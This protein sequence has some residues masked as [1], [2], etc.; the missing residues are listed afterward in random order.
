VGKERQR[1]VARLQDGEV[2]QE[3]CAQAPHELEEAVGGEVVLVKPAL[4]LA[5][6][7]R[8]RLKAQ[9]LFLDPRP[10]LL[11]QRVRRLVGR[12]REKVVPRGRREAGHDAHKLPRQVREVSLAKHA[13]VLAAGLQDLRKQSAIYLSVLRAY[14]SRQVRFLSRD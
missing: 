6:A 5:A 7:A 14:P 11:L 12:A 3:D 1:G 4:R 10:K 2:L 8:A 13:L 9:L